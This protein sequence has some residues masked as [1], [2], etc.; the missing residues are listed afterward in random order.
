MSSVPDGPSN[1]E[2]LDAIFTGQ[3]YSGLQLSSHRVA[4]TILDTEITNNSECKTAITVAPS[5]S[6]STRVI[7]CC[8]VHMTTL[9]SQI[10]TGMNDTRPATRSYK[11]QKNL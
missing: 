3:K 2:F 8:M 1:L 6:T 10:T 7:D 9:K 4:Y 5:T 11:N